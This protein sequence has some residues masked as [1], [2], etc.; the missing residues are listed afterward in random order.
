MNEIIDDKTVWLDSA[1][2]KSELQ[3][4]RT[5]HRMFEFREEFEAS[6]EPTQRLLLREEMK[7]MFIRIG[8]GKLWFPPISSGVWTYA[9]LA[10]FYEQRRAMAD[11]YAQDL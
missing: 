4:A 2:D 1:K 8:E 3:V 10:K 5:C 6:K 7:D 9:G 11:A